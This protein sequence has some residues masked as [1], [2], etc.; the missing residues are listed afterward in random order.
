[1]RTCALL[2]QLHLLKRFDAE[3]LAD[4]EALV[5]ALCDADV[6]ADSEALVDALCDAEVLTVQKTSLKRFAMQRCS[7]FA[8]TC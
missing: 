6:T 3:V 2:I 1:M 7:E 4:S 5:E 8:R